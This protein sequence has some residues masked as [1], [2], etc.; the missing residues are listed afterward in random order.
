M[1]TVARHIEMILL[2]V[3]MMISETRREQPQMVPEFRFLP[4]VFITY[5]E[6]FEVEFPPG[7]SSPEEWR[8]GWGRL[9]ETHRPGT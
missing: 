6:V 9:R 8:A 4:A 7:E 1:T 2:Y 5:P 3:S